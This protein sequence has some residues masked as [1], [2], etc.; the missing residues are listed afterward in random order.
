AFWRPPEWMEQPRGFDVSHNVR[1]FPIVSGLQAFADLLNQLTPPPGFGHVYATDYV[2]AWA[3]IVRPKDWTEA[4]TERLEQF[5]HNIAGDESDRDAYSW[6]LTMQFRC[7]SDLRQS[8]D[9]VQR[10]ESFSKRSSSNRPCG[11]RLV[12]SAIRQDTRI[13]LRKMSTK[14]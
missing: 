8:G 1:W 14:P 7:L 5:I 10:P 6:N 9:D 2:K 4:E 11:R 3:S 12:L 13:R